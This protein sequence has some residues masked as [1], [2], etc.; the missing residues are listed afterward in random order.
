MNRFA[1]K[2]E[3]KVRDYEDAGSIAPFVKKLNMI[4]RENP[5]LQIQN[6]LQFCNVNNEKLIAYLKRVEDNTLLIVVSLDPLH[7]QGGMVH[8]PLHELGFNNDHQYKMH[9]LITDQ[10]YDWSGVENFVEISDRAA[11]IHVFRVF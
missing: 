3:L 6:N 8:L 11:P 7:S 10:V 2:Y 5:A 9:D 1:Q 4:R